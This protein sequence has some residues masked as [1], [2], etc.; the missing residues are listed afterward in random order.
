MVR[1]AGFDDDPIVQ[2]AVRE[3]NSWPQWM[4]IGRDNDWELQRR[5][6]SVY[7]PAYGKDPSAKETPTPVA[8]K[9]SK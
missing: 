8:A 9:S 6:L 2:K 3:V 1:P 4:R 7:Y 5:G